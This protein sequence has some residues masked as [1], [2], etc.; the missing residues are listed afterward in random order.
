MKK[1]ITVWTAGLALV[2]CPL[3]AGAQDLLI[4]NATV[5][6]VTRGTLPR[7]DILILGGII[8]RIEENIEAPKGVRVV[9]ATGKF[10]VPGLFDSHTHIGVTDL[11]EM[12]ETITPE[13]SVADALNA[14]D[15]RI[16]YC[17]TGGVT[18]V[19]TMHGS[20]NPIGGRNVTLKMKWGKTAEEMIVP[21]AFPTIK[22]AQGENIKQSYYN[23]PTPRYPKSRMGVAAIVRR[24]LL[25]ARSYMEEWD[26][27][28]A[29]A[30]ARKP[31]G[32]LI[33]PR[34][35]LRLETLADVLRGKLL[36]R[37]HTYRADE[38]LEMIN[39][40]RELGFKIACMDHA[41]EAFKIAKE[42]AAA[43]IGISVFT[44]SWSYKL[45]TTEGIAYNAAACAKQGVLV[46]LNSDGGPQMQYMFNEAAKTMKFG[47][48][49]ADEA[50]KLITINP[51]IQLGVDKI[52]GSL[53]AGK[54][55]D[56]AIFSRHPLDSYTRCEMTIIEGDVYFD[57]DQ[58]VKERLEKKT[59]D[60]GKDKVKKES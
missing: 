1:R 55:G 40:S 45:E 39:L 57:R 56:V 34:T 52:V 12:G 9:D 33:P 16:F 25:K 53:E 31:G 51:A 20:G 24:E 54:H 13:V 8:R 26:R 10:A 19:H 36:V 23:P 49:S 50:L 58:Y 2:L 41:S 35:D 42:L 7:G 47:G 14:E 48:L 15:I 59:A 22:F 46:S 44:D 32:L 60:T 37:C 17:L 4:K 38:T 27:Y 43:G 29:A 28:R 30:G 6:T 3:A 5:L 18:M 11:N 21:Q